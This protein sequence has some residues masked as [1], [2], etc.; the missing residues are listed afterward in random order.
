[1]ATKSSP[2]EKTV[3]NAT[4]DHRPTS[5]SPTAWDTIVAILAPLA[6]LRLTV[7]LFAMSIFIVFAGTLAQ[8][9][10]DIWQVVHDYFRMDLRSPTTAMQSALSW[11]DFR[12]FFPRSFFPQMQEIPWGYGFFFP[13]GWLI[14]FVLFLNLTAAHLIRFRI[15]GKGIRLIT[16]S[17]IILAGGLLTAVV[18]AAGSQQTASQ[19]KLFSDWPSLRILWLLT[20]CTVVSV[21]LLVGCSLVFRKRA[22]IVLLHSGVGLLMFGELLVG[23]AAIEGQMQVLEGETVN[24]VMDTRES[25]LA[26]IDTSGAT[27]DEVVAVPQSLLRRGKVIKDEHLPF[28]VELVEYLPN[29]VLRPAV[30]GI[31]NM[32]TAGTGLRQIAVPVAPIS[33]TD[34]TGRMNSP[35]AYVRLYDKGTDRPL[36]VY[37]VGYT[38]WSS[39]RPEKV[40]VGDKTYDLYLR[41]KHMYKPYSMHLIDVKHDQYMGTQTAKNYSSELR[42]VDPA[43][44]VDRVVKIWMNNPLRFAG[45]TFY[46]SN[47]GRSPTTGVEYT[48]LQVVTNTGWRIPYVSCMMVVIGM[49]AQFGITLRRFLQRRESGRI[50]P[51]DG[52]NIAWPTDV[53][54]KQQGRSGSASA[55]S[56]SATKSSKAGWLV[57]TAVVVISAL[58]IA[59][60]SYQPPAPE[61]KSDLAAFG[62]LP[63]VYEGRIKPFDTLARN[64]LRILSD[65][66]TYTDENN[67]RQ[68]AVRWL[69]DVIT[70]SDAV[71]KHRVFRIQSLEVLDALGLERR[72]GFRYSIDDFAPKL[73]VFEQ[74]ARIARQTPPEHRDLF[75][76]K[77]LELDQKLHL[78]L[79]LRE[80]FRLPRLRAE[81]LREDLAAEKNRREEYANAILPLAVPPMPTPSSLS[82]QQSADTKDDG[83][84]EDAWQPFTFAVFDAL[85]QR[86]AAAQGMKASEPNP[87]TIALLNILSD[88][89]RKT[90]SGGDFNQE[91]AAYRTLLESHP[92]LHWNVAKTDFEAFFN[93]FSPTFYAMILYIFAFVLGCFSWLGWSVPL[94]RATTW[95]TL[96]TFVVHSL[97][98]V[99]RMY[100]S[101]RPPDHQPVLVGDF[102][103][104]GLR[105]VGVGVGTLFQDR[106]GQCHCRVFRFWHTADCLPDDHG[107]P[108]IQGRLVHR[109]S[110]RAGHAVLVGHARHL[111]DSRLFGDVRSRTARHRLHRARRAN[112]LTL[113]GHG[114]RASAA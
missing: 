90:A 35:T 6:S 74:Q 102:H 22:G 10:K 82:P 66:Q 24:A 36:G 57:P 31:E 108:F 84:G 61:G 9:E 13:S 83:Q 113:R 64:S 86:M 50:S 26:A 69:L 21:V 73:N 87:A 17:V 103:R 52:G 70:D 47:Y 5:S 93:H 58:W 43:S 106:R 67:I 101:G 41:Y 110:G 94:R 11:I 4:T 78:Y 80:S 75:G 112:A 59:G 38:Q 95:L 23:V 71:R 100:I 29:S 56:L 32:A 81:S 40:Q 105:A 46:Q 20:Q 55:P 37:M 89:D 45:E 30:P 1:M 39:G 109:A 2:G 18:I 104:L 96:F 91:V 85:A 98:L 33:G 48:G 65:K 62:R 28:D 54:R 63:V 51:E 27:E 68:P 14:G 44:N 49:L 88:Y 72:K 7:V 12:I 15:Q 97:A 79:I 8:T 16:G 60:K 114:A 3:S 77:I 53:P 92:P 111:R 99:G 19:L 42:L 76:K 107:R 25:E 34:N